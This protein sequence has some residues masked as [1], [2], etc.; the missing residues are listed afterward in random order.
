MKID[1][2]KLHENIHSEGELRGAFE[3][4]ISSLTA[5]RYSLKRNAHGE[6]EQ[7]AVFHMWTG[8]CMRAV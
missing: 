1:Y 6:Y 2:D 5:V 4:F 3:D 8:W 7:A